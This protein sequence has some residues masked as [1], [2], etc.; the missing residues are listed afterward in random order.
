MLLSC[1]EDP[2][3][4]FPGNVEHHLPDLQ[5]LVI[6]IETGDERGLNLV[7]PKRDANAGVRVETC[8]CAVGACEHFFGIIGNFEHRS[9]M[10]ARS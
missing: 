9:I 7:F 5:D 6:F 1:V 8:C 3:S 4:D 2:V 10:L